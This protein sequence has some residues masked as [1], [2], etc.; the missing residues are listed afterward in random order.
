[1][2][3]SLILP[4][5]NKNATLELAAHQLS[6]KTTLNIFLG[7]FSQGVISTVEKES[8]APPK[9]SDQTLKKEETIFDLK[10]N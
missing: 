5:G 2:A 7:H 3:T 4:S 1:M 6:G 9:I 10:K 8:F